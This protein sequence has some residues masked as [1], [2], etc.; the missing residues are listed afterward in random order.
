MHPRLCQV[1]KGVVSVHHCPEMMSHQRVL[2]NESDLKQI[3][4]YRAMRTSLVYWYMAST[5]H[6]GLGA[7]E[8]W[9]HPRCCTLDQVPLGLKTAYRMESPKPLLN[10]VKQDFRFGFSPVTNK[11]QPLTLRTPA[12]FWTMMRTSS[13]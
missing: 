3:P 13:P 10:C 9:A 4:V 8:E 7:R 1:K 11:K 2:P 12:N 6:Q 5:P